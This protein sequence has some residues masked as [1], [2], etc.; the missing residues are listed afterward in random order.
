MRATG[1]RIS[2]AVLSGG[3]LILVGVLLLLDQLYILPSH[4]FSFWALVLFVIGILKIL[5][6]DRVSGWL[7]GVSL[8]AAG[9]LFELD[10]LGYAHIRLERLWPV[11]VI[12][13]GVLVI[14]HSFERP[15][16]TVSPSG[17]LNLFNV[18]GGGEYRIQS[19]NFRGGYVTAVMGGFDIDLRDAD[20][21]EQEAK[22]ELNA[23]LGGGVIKVP[24]TWAVVMQGSSVMGGYSMKIRERSE[25]TKTLIVGGIAVLGGVEI[26][27]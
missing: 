17:D 12:A 18:M 6:S 1:R 13:A 3:V 16:E 20:M 5:Q 24:E 14:V 11:F 7:W 26:R 27:N 19:K 21:E 9:A 22:I 2:P 8:I 15:G 25:V 23:F 10:Y 4:W